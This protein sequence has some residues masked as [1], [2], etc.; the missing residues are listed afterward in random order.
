MCDILVFT[1]VGLSIAG[2]IKG[3]PIN[4]QSIRNR[5]KT[6][7]YENGVTVPTAFQSR[8]VGQPDPYPAEISSLYAL[9][10]DNKYKSDLERKNIKVVL[11]HS[12]KEGQYCAK[13]IKCLIEDSN[14]FPKP[15][16][17]KWFCELVELKDLDPRN[18]EKFPKAIEELFEAI[19][20]RI[21]DSSGDVFVNITGGYKGLLPYLTMFGMAQRRLKVFYLYED[22]TAIIELPTYPFSFDLFAWRDQ[23]GLILPFTLKGVLKEDQKKDLYHALKKE[24]MEGVVTAEL[25]YRLSALGKTMQAIYKEQ[26]GRGISEFGLG[27]LLLND[28]QEDKWRNYLAKECIPIWRHLA[29]GDHI[30]ETVEHGRGHT[31]R[32]LELAQQLLINPQKKIKLSDEQLFV[33]ISSI[34]LHDIGHSGDYFTFEGE[35]G[36]VRKQDQDKCEGP[37]FCLGDPERVR[38]YHNFLT[39]ELIKGHCDRL[40]P[41]RPCWLT[42][43]LLN[44]IAL[45]C[46]YHRKRMPVRNGNKVNKNVYVA[47]GLRDFKEKEEVIEGFPL[48]ASLLRFIDGAENQEERTGSNEYYEIAQWV[49]RRQAKALECMINK[50]TSSPPHAADLAQFKNKQK[51][52]FDK[53]RMVRSV[54]MAWED[55]DHDSQDE[56]HGVFGNAG[57]GATNVL[58]VYLVG[59]CDF[60]GYNRDQVREKIVQDLL[61]EFELVKDILRFRL[62]IYLVEEKANGAASRFKL[63]RQC[64]AKCS[65]QEI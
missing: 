44:S 12:P 7:I 24:G 13:G 56:E 31:Q 14:Y 26:R 48:V 15:N 32:L 6:T 38:G 33:L 58:G 18:A 50:N 53:H 52:E 34:W 5:M 28:F 29:V 57:P 43:L 59:N 40:F 55:S 3:E 54:F 25:G 19:N 47:K 23:R 63:I 16:S 8:K 36:L 30:P 20:K 51:G 61:D 17:S 65:L 35:D 21:T 45:A 64:G 62:V 9:S 2:D 42:K 39:Y 60:K 41:N 4:I 10:I 46:L 11:L 22:S 49:L 1:P 27:F 37:F